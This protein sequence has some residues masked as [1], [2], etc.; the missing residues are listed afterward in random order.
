M[1]TQILTQAPPPGQESR[2][3]N[4]RDY[5]DAQAVMLADAA[6]AAA[7]AG[8]PRRAETIARAMPDGYRIRYYK[9]V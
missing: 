3:D 4:P 2:P 5:L 8:R 7:T 9:I 6:L 1:S